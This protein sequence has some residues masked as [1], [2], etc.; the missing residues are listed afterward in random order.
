M[1]SSGKSK[2]LKNAAN[3]IGTFIGEGAMNWVLE[4]G[5]DQV[6]DYVPFI[7]V[8]LG[9]EH[10]EVMAKLDEIS[11]LINSSTTRIVATTL[12]TGLS[13]HMATIRSHFQMLVKRMRDLN[14]SYDDYC[15]TVSSATT[16]EALDYIRFNELSRYAEMSEK[17]HDAVIGISEILI[18]QRNNYMREVA[19]VITGKYLLD[20]LDAADKELAPYVSAILSAQ[21][22]QRVIGLTHPHV[23]NR[24]IKDRLSIEEDTLARIMQK[25]DIEF[26]GLL[27]FR[28]NIIKDVYTAP[29]RLYSHQTGFVVS[30]SGESDHLGFHRNHKMHES[31]FFLMPAHNRITWLRKNG[32]VA[33]GSTGLVGP[34]L[35]V[36]SNEGHPFN[37]FIHSFTDASEQDLLPDTDWIDINGARNARQRIPVVCV[38]GECS[39]RGGEC[40]FDNFYGGNT[41][42]VGSNADGNFSHQFRM[43]PISDRSLLEPWLWCAKCGGLWSPSEGTDGVCSGGGGHSNANSHTFFVYKNPAVGSPS[44]NLPKSGHSGWR[45]CTKCRGLFD[46]GR[47][48]LCPAGNVHAHENED[49][50]VFF[51]APSIVSGFSA[52]RPD[53]TVFYS[54][55]RCCSKC[56]GMFYPFG[57]VPC[58]AG[59]THDAGASGN[60]TLAVNGG[61]TLGVS[62]LG[63]WAYQSQGGVQ[64]RLRHGGK[65]SPAYPNEEF[66]DGS[67]QWTVLE[68]AQSIPVLMITWSYRNGTTRV[69]ALY[70]YSDEILSSST[71]VLVARVRA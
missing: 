19:G 3:V 62:L 35:G 46:G 2:A 70:K 47:Q 38:R 39:N 67:A 8:L 17:I 11:Q 37:L 42:L 23:A 40:E 55:W 18:E 32:W 58:P 36:L 15:N 50:S 49:Y 34:S 6:A 14:L 12:Q 60:Y 45:R 61:M 51:E 66:A 9:R 52:T 63:T 26:G 65:V 31:L 16:A 5:V 30:V 56:A 4:K 41:D 64:F 21:A 24:T 10:A 71:G 7:S 69:E 20:G 28:S 13:P 1:G 53:P 59:G 22:M 44:A 25:A 33:H 29:F 68:N 43:A 57:N 27:T 48:S 54:G